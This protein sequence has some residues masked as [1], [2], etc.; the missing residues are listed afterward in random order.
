[1]TNPDWLNLTNVWLPYT[2][3]KNVQTPY[4]VV[5]AK[6]AVVVNIAH[7]PLALTAVMKLNNVRSDFAPRGSL[8]LKPWVANDQGIRSIGQQLQLQSDHTC[9]PGNKSGQPSQRVDL[10]D[11]TP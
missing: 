4:P 6:G 11:H 2:Q 8:S 7:I 5:S 10:S 1:M 9:F 3:M